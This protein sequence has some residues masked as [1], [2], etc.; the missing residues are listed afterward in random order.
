MFAS[1]M[2]E[3]KFPRS[4]QQLYLLCALVYLHLFSLTKVKVVVGVVHLRRISMTFTL[5]RKPFLP[6]HDLS[7]T[8]LSRK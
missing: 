4:T 1:F 3:S 7:P 5:R 8:T 6:P 2:R